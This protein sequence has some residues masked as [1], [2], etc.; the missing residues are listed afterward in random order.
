[1]KPSLAAS[2]LI[3]LCGL[4]ILAQ[5]TRTTAQFDFWNWYALKSPAPAEGIVVDPVS[6]NILYATTKNG[7]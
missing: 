1:M 3:L 5:G 7:L 4:G 6:D 2:A